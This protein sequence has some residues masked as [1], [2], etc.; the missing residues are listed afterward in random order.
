MSDGQHLKKVAIVGSGS[1][2]IGALWAL[3]RTHHDVYLYEAADRLGGHTNTVE[4]K[5][6]KYRTLVDTGFIVLNEATYPNFMNFLKQVKVPTVPTEM[7][8][9][10]SRDRGRFEWAGTSLDAIFCQRRNL[11]SLKMWRL[12]FDIIRFNQFALDLLKEDENSRPG[13]RGTISDT[14]TIGQYLEREGYSEAFKND[15]LIPMTAAVW[16]TSPDRCSLEF[17]AVTLIRFMWNHHLLSTIAKRPDWLTLEGGAKSYIDAVM[18][19]FPPNHLFLKTA[20]RH[21]TNEKNGRV[22]LH[23]ENGKSDV[24]DHVVLATHGDQAY[25]IIEP[26]AT[27]DEKTIMS[28]FK[29]SENNCI[30]HSDLSHMPVNTKSWTS[31]NYITQSNPWTGRDVDK[32][33]LT[34]NMNIL[35]HIP[36]GTFGDVLVTLNPLHEPK[37]ET[38]QGRYS[39][40]HPLYTASAIQAQNALPRIQNKRNISYAGAWTKYGFHEDGFSSGLYVAQAHLGARLPFEFVDTT[41]IRGRQPQLGIADWL[42]RVVILLIQVFIIDVL[43]RVWENVKPRIS[44]QVN[45]VKRMATNKNG[46]LA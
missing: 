21:L 10:I 37:E 31:W 5:R 20:V 2:G 6:G 38:I 23:F 9:G 12:I 28:A 17:P 40:S 18:K 11:F 22:R 7:T 45:G 4:W 19:G 14:E 29:T 25:Q 46:K 35:Q 44:R 15:Y 39:Y 13:G 43:E 1:A 3:N 26:S 24:F 8:F 16:S 30:L 36:R 41:Y 33:S 42:A 34:Y 32:V 27:E